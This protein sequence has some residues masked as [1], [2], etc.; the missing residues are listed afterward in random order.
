MK[1]SVK[2][3][4][5]IYFFFG[6]FFL[7]GALVLTMLLPYLSLIL[8]AFIIATSARPIYFWLYKHTKENDSLSVVGTILFLLF[9]LGIPI[10][11][12]IA[13]TVNQVQ[14]FAEDINEFSQ[15]QL[16][17]YD[18]FGDVLDG[19]NVALEQLPGDVQISEDQIVSRISESAGPASEFI[20]DQ[21]LS[22]GSNSLTIMTNSL[23]FLILLATFISVQPKMI[24]FYKRLSP[25]DNKLDDILISRVLEMSKSMLNGTFVVALVQGV[26]GGVLLALLGVP[27]AFFFG[28]LGTFL[29]IIPLG[30]GLIQI[31][32]GLVQILLGNV[33]QGVTII[34]FHFLV[35]SNVDNLLRPRLVKKEVRLPDAYTLLGIFGGISL[36]G[37]LGFIYGPVLMILFKS[38]LDVYLEYYKD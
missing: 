11:L 33:W 26:L 38:L 9:I 31:P 2:T 18:S 19:L 35:T 15:N 5:N 28:L 29:A 1:T 34:L 3:K 10:A 24:D 4:Q 12:V 14:V 16:T 27:Y 7:V 37:F 17:E 21:L 30:S 23:L 13:I 36:F 20:I 32:I 8:L 25:L 22:F 6:L